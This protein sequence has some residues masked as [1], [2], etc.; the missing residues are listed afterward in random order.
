[1]FFVSVFV[2]ST[3]RLFAVPE[4]ILLFNKAGLKVIKERVQTSAYQPLWTDILT[5]ADGFGDPS[6][7]LYA[8]PVGYIEAARKT[9]DHQSVH[10]PFPRKL[11]EWMETLGFAHAITGKEK[12]RKNAIRLLQAGLDEN[13]EKAMKGSLMEGVR[14]DMM[15]ALALG[16]DMFS[17]VMTPEQR[18]PI[19]A[20]AKGYI[21]FL[22]EDYNRPDSKWHTTRKPHNF[23]GV[24][25]GALGMLAIALREDFPEQS[26]QWMALAE[27]IILDWFDNAFDDQG[28]NVEGVLYMQ[29]GTGNA[30]MF[31]DAIY[32][33]EKRRTIID[34]PH[35]KMIPYFLAMQILPGESAYDARNDS[36]Y[37][38]RTGRSAGSSAPVLLLQ[39]SGF[40]DAKQVDPLAAWLWDQSRVRDK[41][42]MMIIWHRYGVESLGTRLPSPGIIIPAPY[43]SHFKGRGLCV[44]RTG[45]TRDDTMFSIEAGPYHP[46]SH[47][48]ADKGHFT[49]YGLGY[50]WA[51]DVGYGND[52]DPNGRCQTVAHSCVLVDGK[53]QALSGAALGT[54]G[55]ILKYANEDT[56]GYALVD[57]KSAY[58]KNNA[59]K[60][61]VPLSKALRH[62]LYIRP[63]GGI[64]AYAVVIDD[65]EQEGENHA[66]TWQMIT[67]QDMTVRQRRQ[68]T[69]IVS[70]PGKSPGTPRMKVQ[71]RAAADILLDSEA[72]IPDNTPGRAP[73]EY[74]KLTATTASS[75]KN[76]KFVAL[77]APLPASYKEE[78]T[79]T[80]KTTGEG[81]LITVRWPERT[82]LIQL[83]GDTATL[84]K[85]KK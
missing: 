56:H 6:S 19:V 11:S 50:R 52:R 30:L 39:A 80:V 10:T 69:F 64:P 83:H 1:L 8:D 23:S 46:I 33:L 37:E 72:Y 59:G 34:H 58:N 48:Q 3:S 63:A 31:A 47:N 2:A 67:W 77:L 81:E 68:D 45:W 42:I 28:A 21:D 62:A 13:L 79:M 12:Y 26:R 82:D 76:P 73:Y 35:Q 5:N 22:E 14:G 53:G 44:W 40:N 61:G 15:R 54:D 29:Y 36:L 75:I 49:F 74:K 78:P 32:R 66:F 71:I 51:A 65:I 18:A 85:N 41:N 55:K 25:G 84:I 9:K 27:R 43:G 57:A 60:V 17:S 7:K 70:P 16:L 24:C 4:Q 38:A 20:A